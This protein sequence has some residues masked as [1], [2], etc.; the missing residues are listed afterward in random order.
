LD[1]FFLTLLNTQEINNMVKNI[2]VKAYDERSNTDYDL[3]RYAFIQ[4]SEENIKTIKDKLEI[5]KT[6]SDITA[7]ELK[8][9]GIVDFIKSDSLTEDDEANIKM[10]LNLNT[11]AL[12]NQPFNY[13]FLDNSDKIKI[14]NEKWKV[15]NNHHTLVIDKYGWVSAW[16]ISNTMMSE[17]LETTDIKIDEL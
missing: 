9:V 15:L 7:I 10:L 8:D 16:A 13:C 4:L 1:A 2:L 6:Y 12:I 5:F 14:Y 3:C 11:V 17:R